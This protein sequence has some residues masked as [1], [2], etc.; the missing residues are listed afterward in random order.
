[1]ILISIVIPCRNEEKYIKKTID[2]I[3]SQE[4]DY[5]FEVIVV[6]GNSRDNTKSILNSYKKNNK[7]E[8]IILDN[9]RM[10]VP[11]GFN[12]GLSQARGEYIIRV[13]AHSFLEPGFL[14]NCI[15][16]IL[17]IDADC[18]GGST[19]HKSAG[20]IGKSIMICQTSNF[21]SG[22]VSFRKEVNQGKYVN[23][24]AFGAYK[25][26]VFK[27]IGGYDEELV[28]NQDDEFN[29]RLIQNGGKI[30]LDPSI[31]S[32]Y[33]VRRSLMGFAKQYF[34]Y[35]FYKIRVMQKRGGPIS[36]RHLVPLTFLSILFF[37]T[38]IFLFYQV[39]LP[40]YIFACSYL[41]SSIISSL[42]E[43][44]TLKHN[45]ISILLLPITY[46]IMHFSYGL[47][48]LLG[49]F[50]FMN[51]WSDKAVKDDNFNIKNFS[52]NAKK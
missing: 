37:T 28:R 17:K 52:D 49:L 24:L 27:S 6:D 9:P 18:V 5:L 19:I 10:I 11:V 50:Y 7:R 43:L 4:C 34:Q 23:T 21:G 20:T 25:R 29:Y 38:F 39:T 14:K 12:I 26:S 1:M 45:L 31:K 42:L 33:F 30:W 46:F 41:A 44:F 32:Y 48:S 2:S 3:F 13:D 51:K 16:T 40:F 35:G 36:I 8:L 47:G 15:N 22:G